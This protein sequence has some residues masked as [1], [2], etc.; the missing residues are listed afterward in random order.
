M[1]RRILSIVFTICIIGCGT[2]SSEGEVAPVEPARDE[3]SSTAPFQQLSGPNRIVA[4]EAEHFHRRTK[5]S[6]QDEWLLASALGGSSGG[7]YLEIG[8]ND[9]SAQAPDLVNATKLDFDVRFVAGGSHALWIRAAA[10]G[11]KDDSVHVAIDGVLAKADWLLPQGCAWGWFSTTVNVPSPGTHAVQFMMH[12]DGFKIDKVL[13]TTNLTYVPTALGPV[14]SGRVAGAR[15]YNPGHFIALSQ[16]DGENHATVLDSIETADG[17]ARPGIKGVQ[18]RYEWR[19]LE[20]T[21]GQY[22]FTRLKSDLDLVASKGKT[23]VV[24]IQDKTY[25]SQF[26]PNPD[27][28][29]P[30]TV[31]YTK[32]NPHGELI[33]CRTMMRW[34]PFVLERF[35]ALSQAIGG[36]FDNHPGL[37]GVSFEESALGPLPVLVDNGYTP[38]LYRDAL[39]A[40]LTSLKASLSA[41]QVFWYMNFIPG[42]GASVG[43]SRDVAAA[44]APLGVIM[45]GPDILPEDEALRLRAYPL[46]AFPQADGL[47][48]FAGQMTLFCSAQNESFEHLKSAT[49]MMYTPQEIFE[50]AR[51]TLHVKYVFWNHKTWRKRAGAHVWTDALPVIAANPSFNEELGPH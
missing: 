35:A 44:V 29:A 30:Y 50:F 48:G 51:D 23:V 33:L 3:L 2:G 26:V 13:L 37:E 34:H 4:M 21:Q 39:I 11:W 46:Y 24:V 19:E 32:T 45:G 7:Q 9:G 43:Y 8:P 27:Y 42:Q 16:R 31:T 15:K 49:G 22:D 38:E 41:S 5:G 40:M 47:G 28:L 12:K 1:F 25:A 18:I 17:A 14:E 36:Q 10:C 20:P 6:T